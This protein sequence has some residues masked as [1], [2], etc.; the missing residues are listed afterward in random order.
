M[1]ITASEIKYMEVHY[2]LH[3][4]SH[5]HGKKKFKNYFPE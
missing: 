5:L 3:V 1:N 4:D 2:L